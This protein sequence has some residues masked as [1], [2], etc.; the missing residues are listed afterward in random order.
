MGAGNN[1]GIKLA[2]TDYVL[3]LNPDVVLEK[4]TLDELFLASNELSNFSILSPLENKIPN[5]G[6]FKENYDVKIVKNMNENNLYN[7][8]NEYCIKHKEKIVASASGIW[9]ILNK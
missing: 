6:S 3:I 1:I 8:L 2:K 4:N 7:Q 5:Y 9:K